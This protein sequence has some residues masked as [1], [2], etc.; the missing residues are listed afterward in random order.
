LVYQGRLLFERTQAKYHEGM[1]F[2]EKEVV[3]GAPAIIQPERWGVPLEAVHQ[4][5]DR[6]RAYW[7]RYRTCFKTRTR[8]GSEYAYDY[9]SGQLRLEAG[10]NYANIARQ[11]GT[12]EQNMQH[13]M[14]N[15][16]WSCAGIYRQI[17]KDIQATS[18]LSRGGVL[19]LDESAEEKAGD[20]SAGAQKQHNGRL[21]KVEMSQ[22]GVF[23]AYANLKGSPI[24]TW[25]NGDLFLPEAWLTDEMAAQR[26]ELEVPDTV[27]FRTK[28]E[29]GWD[30]IRQEVQDYGLEVEVVC[31][32]ALYGRSAWLREQLR[33]ASLIYMADIPCD[34]PVYLTKPEV[35]VPPRR[36]R[37]GRAPTRP[38]V[39]SEDTPVEVR[40]LVQ[41]EETVWQRLRIRHTERGELCDKFAARRVWTVHAG[42]AIPEW[43][44]IRHERSGRY[45]Y[46]LSN[47]PKTTPLEQLA[48]W[49][50]QR[51][52]VE[53]SNQD[54]KSELGWD[55]FQA[56]KFPAWQHHV[57]CTVL[58]C[59]FVAQTKLEW[60]QTYAHDPELAHAFEVEVLPMLS[61]ANIRSLL[62]AVLPL[63]QLTPEEATQRVIQHL[64]NR[65]RSRKS[66]LKHPSKPPHL[67]RP[68]G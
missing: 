27:T 2:F 43:V 11:A 52:F 24:W 13:F 68:D 4:L 38:Q 42:R 41:A 21:G 53:R 31:F 67:P 20:H 32:D 6:L 48:W 14:T 34:T 12:S 33:E 9:L 59:W 25:V 37:R 54:A 66:R 47:A 15:S 29:I 28:L 65:T 10:R 40:S 23:L 49:K 18:A 45:R 61:V 63:P 30:L 51:Y 60:A 56:Q 22:V 64:L 35:G 3:M 19:I 16:P 17:A 55:E 5:G 46:A 58:A 8:D 36:S 62:R 44:V 26:C 7:T 57:A 39:L 1:T 50:C